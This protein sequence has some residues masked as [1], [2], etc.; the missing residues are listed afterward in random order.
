M[1]IVEPSGVGE[2]AI[3][4][5][6]DVVPNI[7]LTMAGMDAL[8]GPEYL[9]LRS[10]GAGRSV[11]GVI[12]WVGSWNGTGIFQCSPEFACQLANAMLGVESASLTEDS[13]DAVAEMTNIIFGSMKTK[14]E[15][16][17][18]VTGLSAPTVIYGN[19]V[20][21]R[22]TGDPFT[23]IPVQVG[24]SQVHLK[25]YITR[26]DERRHTLSHYWAASCSGAL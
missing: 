8:A 13:L 14:I 21:M 15:S 24:E 1:T 4:A 12:G 16:H 20:G 9:N 17:L 2:F 6:K 25:I 5:L 3:Q 23:V 10:A 19:D 26:M 22:S 11:A 18:G 7:F